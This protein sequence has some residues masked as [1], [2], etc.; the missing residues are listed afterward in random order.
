MLLVLIDN[1]VRDISFIA[2]SLTNDTEYIIFDFFEDTISSIQDKITKQYDSVG[3]IQHNYKSDEYWLVRDSSNAIVYNLESLDPE[4]NTWQQYID[5]LLWLKNERGV[6]YVDLM[7]CDLWEEPG[8]RYMIETI[9]STRGIYLRASI[10]KTGAGGDFILE[11]DNFNTIGVYFTD[12]IL[13]YKY[14]FYA[15]PY[16][17][18]FSST[19]YFPYILPDSNLA[20]ISTR[21]QALL[22]ANSTTTYTTVKQLI[23]NDG[24][25]AALLSNGNVVVLGASYYGGTMPSGSVTQSDLVNVS[26]LFC[27]RYGGFIAIKTNGSVI[28]WG[29]HNGVNIDLN[30]TT[31]TNYINFNSVRS[32]CVGVIDIKATITAGGSFAALNSNGSVVTWGAKSFGGDKTTAATFLSSGITKI[33]NGSSFFFALKNDGSVVKWGNGTPSY[34]TAF[35]TTSTPVVDFIVTP[36]T[37]TALY[38]RRNGSVFDIL[39]SY[40]ATV[41]YTLP[42]G[43]SVLKMLYNTKSYQTNFFILFSNN[44][45]GTL[46]NGTWTLYTN[47]TDVAVNGSGGGGAFAIIQNGAVIVGGDSGFGGSLT[48]TTTGLKS[49][50]NLTNPVRLVSSELSFGCIKSDNTFVWWGRFDVPYVSINYSSTFPT[51]STETTLYNAYNGL[52]I[53]NVYE[54]VQGYA[55]VKTDGSI[56]I[57]GPNSANGVNN[58]TN[59]GTKDAGTNVYFENTGLGFFALEI[60]YLP[61]V[62]PTSI[63][64]GVIT[65]ISY[66]VSNPDKRA[67]IGRKYRLYNGA[68]LLDSFIP[69]ADTH[70]YVFSSVNIQTGGVQTLTIKDESTIS[71]TVDTFIITVTSQYPCFLQGS[72]IL[73]FNPETYQDE[74]I[75]VEKLRIGDLVFT[76]ESGYKSIHSIGH[77]LLPSP[78]CDPNPSNRLYKFSGNEPLYITGEH[79]TLHRHIPENKRK[80][81]TEHMG[82]VYITEEFYRMPA[83][84]DDRAQPYDRED[85]PVTIWHF[86]LENDN[87]AHNYGVYA[88]GLLVESCAIESLTKKSGMVLVE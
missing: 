24:A 77:R 54:S 25:S 81:I 38:V 2:S 46:L 6:A 27:Y 21:Y 14:A 17:F 35:F 18:N 53:S 44:S 5:F 4:L 12:E 13:N 86:A 65:N 48:N 26:K 62:S 31:D 82:D 55:I 23:S 69:T 73:W 11:S 40:A 9:R 57:L 33:I 68:T 15:M 85:E 29:V 52:P 32:Q 37:D 41:F 36:T 20:K 87:D 28:T 30:T 79:C 75:A 51:N 66:Y 3:I 50:L 80:L 39:L 19:I 63:E 72:K 70:T 58:S 83:F 43:V 47:A 84:L 78:K 42:A 22:G 7:A 59:Y 8:W 10:D 56:V 64:S 74:Y 88:N 49:G 67:Y 34:S 1:R 16:G 61:S 76:A 71:Y 45:V 60:P